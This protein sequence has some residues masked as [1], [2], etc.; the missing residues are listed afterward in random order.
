M[1]NS[2]NKKKK[3]KRI[4]LII[5]SL[6]LIYFV[7]GVAFCIL[8]KRND[9][10]KEKVE[11]G[12]QIKGFEYVLYDSQPKLYK[13]EFKVLK[14]NLEGDSIDYE[15][16]AKSISKMFIIDLYTINNKKNM[17]D[18]G[19]TIFVYPEARDNYKLNVINTLYKYVKSNDNGKRKQDLPEVK[20]VVIDSIVDNKFSIGD[21]SY[22]GY[23]INLKIDYVKDLGYDTNAEIVIIRN[24][25]YLY[26]V[27]KNNA[28]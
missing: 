4:I 15:G 7:G 3:S 26:I 8:K 24:E 14:S 28:G 12:I 9:G 16:Y 27:E 10:K 19:G 20:S 22:D 2:K 5:C 23:K 25:K 18:V 21:V 6:L 13:E 17:Y 1:K 11:V